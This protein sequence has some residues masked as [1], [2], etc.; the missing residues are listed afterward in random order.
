MLIIKYYH[1]KMYKTIPLSSNDEHILYEKL[2]RICLR[3][4]VY[5]EEKHAVNPTSD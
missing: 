5:I 3:K 2:L 4:C 1:E